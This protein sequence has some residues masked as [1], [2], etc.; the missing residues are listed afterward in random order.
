M[1]AMIGWAA[2]LVLGV[3]TAGCNEQQPVGEA[4]TGRMRRALATDV[5]LRSLAP[6]SLKTIPVPKPTNLGWLQDEA[7]AIALGK[8][9]FWDMQ[10]GSDGAVACATC[11]SYAGADGRSVGMRHPGSNGVFEG[12]KVRSSLSHRDFPLYRLARPESARSEVLFDSDDAVGSQGVA[13]GTFSRLIPGEAVELGRASADPGVPMCQ[14]S[15]RQ[16][17][18]RNSPTVI[19][20]V[21]NF[22][23]FW[24]GRAS[25]FFNG[26]NGSGAADPAA[27][28]WVDD[29]AGL[30]RERLL[31]DNSAL[32]SQAVG[33]PM[34]SVEM[35]WYGRSMPTLGR[36]LLGLRPL[37]KQRVHP[38]DSVLGALS[39][40]SGL[41]LN[42]SYEAL[43]ARAFA[44]R[45]WASEKL[46]PEGYRQVEANFA[47]FWGLALQLYQSTLVSD[48]T[49]YDR[50]M[51]GQND[52]LTVEQK[53]GFFIFFTDGRCDE[54]HS[55]P[56]FT[57]ASVSAAAGEK[58]VLT[59]ME[60]SVGSALY[61]IGFYNI[62]VRP[63]AED[64]GVGGVDE[65][66]LP[67]SYARQFVQGGTPALDVCL[68]GNGA[69]PLPASLE[70]TPNAGDSPPDRV[71]VDGAFK[72]PGLR[73]VELTG[74][75]MHNGSMATLDQVLEFY[76]RE[77]NFG[78][79][80]AADFA[81]HMEVVLLERKED[82]EKV[83]RFLEALTDE[84]V[85]TERAPFDHPELVLPDGQRVEAVGAGGGAPLTSFEQRLP[86]TP[87]E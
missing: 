45:Y 15:A 79:R 61:D 83:V 75:Y 24:D 8:A 36:K 3:V 5:Q 77:G 18:T 59:R 30:T 62:G 4:S 32:A 63:T 16:V 81:P 14:G 23:N 46:T 28:V 13:P 42:V 22:R 19:N 21:F 9:F 20:S 82:Q 35:T 71:A 85:R 69:C 78:E 6:P 66:G 26:V 84:R 73:N 43:I 40:P 55:G 38:E 33:P 31:L 87:P 57:A 47:F 54:C 52:A 64:V 53:E 1:R 67:M 76:A 60:M 48:D 70:V 34:N 50:Y 51:E 86:V 29:G 80:N 37:A 65:R 27:R 12:G 2:A 58:K 17:T 72:T 39:D 11:H 44:P 74:P 7:A 25:H 41:G 49:P 56:E 10:V 68:L